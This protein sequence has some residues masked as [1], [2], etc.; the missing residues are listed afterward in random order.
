MTVPSWLG[1][2]AGGVIAVVSLVLVGSLAVVLLAGGRTPP[3][4]DA[5]TAPSPSA[6]AAAAPSTEPTEVST[7]SVS[8]T[9]AVTPSPTL[10]AT[11]E[12]TPQPT[13]EPTPEPTDRPTP[14]PTA[15]PTPDPTP[16]PTPKPTKAPTPDPKPE[17]TSRIAS[18][19]GSFGETMT[20]DGI[21][22]RVSPREPYGD[23]VNCASGKYTEKVSFDL[24]MIWPDPSDAEP[25]W[26]A[27]GPKPFNVNWF[28]PEPVRSGDMIFSGC[29][30][31]GDSNDVMVEYS[32]PGVSMTLLRW[33]FE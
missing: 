9:P 21:K 24:T 28:F 13:P 7:S 16:E 22:V 18:K 31:P 5:S 19:H 4:A 12:P 33:Y 11:P 14:E 20:I 8:P 10:E 15:R 2:L 29:I 27:V 6:A 3:A 32:P 25:P 17:P 23:T 30:R 1:R 26:V